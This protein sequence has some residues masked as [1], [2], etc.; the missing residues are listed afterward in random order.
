MKRLS[1]CTTIAIPLTYGVVA[2]GSVSAA[3]QDAAATYK[4]K[5]AM[6]PRP[7]WQGAEKVDVRSLGEKQAVART[8]PWRG[9]IF[10]GV[11]VTKLD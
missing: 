7:G 9:V 6:Y 3:V 4:A 1:F 5:C 8:R 11:R 2:I 10:S